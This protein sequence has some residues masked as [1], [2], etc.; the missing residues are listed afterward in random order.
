[1][2]EYK[3]LFNSCLKV[4]GIRPR[5][6]KEIR[7]LLAKKS[8]DTDLINQIV[9]KLKNEN[10]IN[11][12]EFAVWYIASRNRTRPRGQRL[13]QQE[14]KQRGVTVPVE[15]DEKQLAKEALQKKDRL[16]K[17]L[18][19]NDYRR[20]AIAYLQYRGFPWSAIEEAIKKAYN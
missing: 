9:A 14:L 20:K 18:S 13:L 5:S 17:N 16:W 7:D 8:T 3:R 10:L 12:S 6:E 15:I 4:L 1:M 19:A 2:E 11:D